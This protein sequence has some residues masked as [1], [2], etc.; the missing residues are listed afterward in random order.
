MLFR[1]ENKSFRRTSNLVAIATG[2]LSAIL[3]L[4]VILGWHTK[5]VSL[6]QVHPDFVPM[7]Y[8]TALGFL[9]CGLALLA[10]VFN[11]SGLAAIN[12]TLATTIGCLTLLEYLAGINLGI[13]ELLMVHYIMVE[14]SHP[15]RMAPN[16]AL[17]FLLAGVTLFTMS[18][19]ALSG[20]RHVTV[21]ILGSLIVV[22]GATAFLGYVTGAE[23]AYGWANYTRMAVH[24]ASG[25][26]VLGLGILALT[27]CQDSNPRDK[28]QFSAPRT[29]SERRRII[30]TSILIMCTASLVVGVGVVRELYLT[31]LEQE[32]SNLLTT[33]DS[34]SELAEAVTR[35]DASHHEDM[36]SHELIIAEKETL[37]QIED[38]LR[39]LGG[40]RETGEFT[41][42]SREGGQMV[43]LL[44]SRHT[45]VETDPLQIPMASGRAEAMRRALDGQSGTLIGLDYRG[46]TVLA[47][48]RP[49]KGLK[50]GLVAKIELAE[51]RR[52]FIRAALLAAGITLVVIAL[53]ALALYTKINPM[54]LRL[55]KSFALEQEV[56]NLG[57][58]MDQSWNEIYLF[59][60]DN[61]SF[62]R[63]NKGA[64][65]NL[66]YRHDELLSLGLL[67]ISPDITR[68]TFDALAA[69][70]RAGEKGRVMFDSQHRRKDGT[71]YPV[72]VG[73]QLFRDE[74]PPLFV[75]VMQDIT[76]RKQSEQALFRLNR[77]LSTLSA[78]NE[79]LV[80]AKDEATLLERICHE[81]VSNSD[82]CMAYVAY[83]NDG[84]LHPVATAD[85]EHAFLEHIHA[86][87]DDSASPGSLAARTRETQLI[88]DFK[89]EPT[90]EPWLDDASTLGYTSI[91]ALPLKNHGTPFG[92]L[93]IYATTSDAFGQEE[94]PLFQEVAE[95]LSYGIITLRTHAEREQLRRQNEYILNAAG[96]GLYGMDSDGRTTFVNPAAVRMFG[97]EE[98]ELLGEYIHDL[99]HHSHED[100]SPYP[101]NQCPIHQ[102]LRDGQPRHVV[103][104]VMWRND[105]SRFSVEYTS[106]P[107]S[108]D[109]QVIGAVVVFSDITERMKTQAEL[110][111]SRQRF[112]LAVQG[113]SDGLWDWNPLTN[114]VW[115][116][117]RFKQLLGYADHELPSSFD[118]WETRLHPDDR[119]HMFSEIQL[120]IDHHKPFDVESRLRTRSDD[121]RWFRT[122][123]QAVRDETGKA[124]RRRVPFRTL[125]SAN[126]PRPN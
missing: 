107:I 111:E 22:L 81:I 97:W 17:C 4:V 26:G 25:F 71:Y 89:A 2:C 116:A 96:E 51:V 109:G 8:N 115:F 84:I 82:Y 102:V 64:Q 5:A 35:Y 29:Q 45:P 70:L 12:A 19:E 10:L 121:Y 27:S 14:V 30:L 100:G 103:G 6:I 79:A 7:Q 33:L 120:H 78:C 85:P 24:T 39:Q 94:L 52:P 104:E 88:L 68:D 47:A 57:R 101:R 86:A 31:A 58:I 119:D 75:A 126:K 83:F 76:Q 50:L 23:T 3:G 92:V 11:Q 112:D 66:G 21:R 73:L 114:E 69:P 13:D 105:G 34:W 117:P 87:C 124:V 59:T 42:A 20:K 125:P 1:D 43:F 90:G 63:V 91:C 110:E 44:H 99:V 37:K 18:G 98:G 108:E 56:Q 53:G 41:I 62:T 74:S 67:D 72:E 93:S 118:A 9:L 122:R 49:L 60:T 77:S 95:D 65:R 55:E 54:I 40:F 48:Y 15:G 113:T 123:G 80:H 46:E 61:L 16:T 28:E 106:T 38:A 32:R 36:H